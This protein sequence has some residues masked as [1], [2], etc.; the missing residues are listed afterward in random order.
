MS[1]I[2]YI[3]PAYVNVQEVMNALDGFIHYHHIWKEDREDSMQKYDKLNCC[4]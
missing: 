1:L 4:H 2:S 3:T